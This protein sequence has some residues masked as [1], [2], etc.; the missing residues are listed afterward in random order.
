MPSSIAKKGV[1]MAALSGA[2]FGVMPLLTKLAYAGGATVTAA[3]TWRF[4]LAALFLWLILLQRH[5]QQDLRLPW[6][7]VLSLFL[8]GALAYGIMSS[9]YFKGLTLLPAS[10]SALFL[11]TYPALVAGLSHLLGEEKLSWKKV[12]A[13]AGSFFGLTLMLGG[14]WQNVNAW[15]S[16][17]GLSAAF[18]YALYILASHRLL[19][20]LDPLLASTYALTSGALVYLLYTALF[21]Q[22]QWSFPAG[23]WLALFGT[24]LISTSVAIALFFQAV[25]L[26][27]APLASIISTVEPVV[28]IILSLLFLGERLTPWQAL[29][30]MLILASILWLQWPARQS[31]SQGLTPAEKRPG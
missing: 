18:T 10:L 22:L 7:D 19:K 26:I 15:G 31:N 28:T 20:R 13:L 11:Y 30:G 25:K 9:L 17:Y 8:L 21:G 23:T 5:P 1:A 12:W 14:S 4:V 27:G 2:S 29:G 3:L 16:F 24:A 6:P